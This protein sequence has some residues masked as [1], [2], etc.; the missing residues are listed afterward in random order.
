MQE[1]ELRHWHRTMGIILA[2]FILLQ[3]GSG[4]MMALEHFLNLHG[5]FGPL[6]KLHF[7]GG[8]LGHIYRIILGLGVMGMATSGTLIFLKIRARAKK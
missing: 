7:G 3:A 2:L 6:T 5:L 4:A 8:A 1:V